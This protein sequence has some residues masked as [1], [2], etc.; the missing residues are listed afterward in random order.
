MSETK[1]Y[2]LIRLLSSVLISL[3]LGILFILIDG[4]FFTK[5]MFIIFGVIFIFEGILALF[6]E[7]V[8]KNIYLLISN[9]ISIILGILIIFFQNIAV[10]II[11]GVYFIAIPIVLLIL[12]RQYFKEE[13]PKQLPRLVVGILVLVLG[14]GGF[15]NILL[16]IFGWLLIAGAIIYL[17][18]GSISLS[19]HE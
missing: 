8:R 5:V 14:L 18:L 7:E 2:L 4:A 13:L 11:V 10:D 6:Y 16:D 9:I 15:V 12:R 19:K 17:I 1:K 3:A